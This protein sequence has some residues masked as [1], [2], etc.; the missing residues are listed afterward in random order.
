MLRV[1]RVNKRSL[2]GPIRLPKDRME[3]LAR[4]CQT[5]DSWFKVWAESMVPKLMYIPKWFR[6]DED[7]QKGDLVYFPKEE[8]LGESRWIMGMVDDMRYYK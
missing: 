4:V 1:G 2:D 3:I 8:T 5:Y 7:L 6:T